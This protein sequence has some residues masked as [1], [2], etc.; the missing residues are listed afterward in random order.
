MFLEK[1]RIFGTMDYYTVWGPPCVAKIV[2]GAD[3]K[4]GL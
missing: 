2:T 1:I 4:G 3:S